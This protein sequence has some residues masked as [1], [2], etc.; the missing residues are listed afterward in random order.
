MF[1]EIIDLD[2]SPQRTVSDEA[3][4]LREKATE[5]ES[6]VAEIE[7]YKTR[8]YAIAVEVS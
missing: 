4:D 3:K 6:A 2:L 8:L 1:S 5:L 7:N